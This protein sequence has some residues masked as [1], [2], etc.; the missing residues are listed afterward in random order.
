VTVGAR[1][2]AV[3]VALL[4]GLA[5][6]CRGERPEGSA[7]VVAIANSPVNL[8]PRVG[9]DEASQK[10]HQ[11]L[12]GSL[13]RIDGDLQVVPDLA[14]SLEQETPLTYVARLRRG[15]LFHNGRELTSADVVY[16]FRSFLDP[17][18]RGRS[19]AYR[20]LAAVDARDRYTVQFTLKE[21]FASFPVNL[22]M[23]IVQDGSGAANART[24]V[25]TGPY[26]LAEF[27]Q[28]DRVVLAPFDRA[29][30]GRPANDGL[31]IKVVPDDTMR[32][33]ELR[34]GTVDLVVNDLSPD[35]IWQL[36]AEGRLGVETAPGSDYAYVGINL[37]DASLAHADVRK[38]IGFAIDR[39]AIVTHLRRGFA[40]VAVGV[41]PPMS[42]AFERAVFDF[43]YDPEEA[44]RLLD[45]AG[46]PD[47]DGDGPQPRLRLTLKTSTSEIYRVQAAVIQH[48][49]AKVG[50]A[51]DV[52]SSEFQTLLADVVRGN[53]QL[54]T[55]QWVGVTDPDMLRR[56]YHSQQIPPAGLNRVAYRNPEVD[57]LIE[58]A[59]E[60]GDQ[61]ARRAA[62]AR[63]QQLIADDVPYVSLWY[64]T[65]VA[66][67]QRDLEGVRL[68]PIADFT[69]L[70]DVHRV[71]SAAHR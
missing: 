19:G 62:Y 14:E 15:V 3:A 26:R 27:I 12:Y 18:F 7:I 65:N 38:A 43:T 64:K 35:V 69:F 24:P 21:P 42:W 70:K 16:T 44:R 31:V 23:G 67:F 39:S 57:A 56:V 11:L 68:S 53:F 66:V 61:A 51:V 52:R 13:M 58:S 45:R 48:D 25:G 55:L 50:I 33:L 1:A 47:P 17:S 4:A 8:D 5:S 49:L 22:V 6:G 34:K 20:N 36:R 63:A 37:R 41:I 32:G 9:A 60:A 30:T 71:S 46:F 59:A 10:A 54:Y 40:T 29:Y 2:L 28:D